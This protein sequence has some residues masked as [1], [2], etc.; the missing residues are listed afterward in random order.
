MTDL[1]G[2]PLDQVRI[3]PKLCR[4][5][6]GNMD[7]IDDADWRKPARA[8][9]ALGRDPGK[10]YTERERPSRPTVVLVKLELTV[11]PRSTEEQRFV[12]ASRLVPSVLQQ[13]LGTRVRICAHCE[14]IVG[15]G[16]V[17]EWIAEK[18]RRLLDALLDQKQRVPRLEQD[19]YCKPGPWLVAIR[20]PNWLKAIRVHLTVTSEAE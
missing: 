2:T 9:Y 20:N 13:F 19:I 11:K 3:D 1:T 17:L 15:D 7:T 18:N 5:L 8:C 4:E 12:V 10:E 16:F 6:K 14:D